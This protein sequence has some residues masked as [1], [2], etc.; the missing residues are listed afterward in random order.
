MNNV[1]KLEEFRVASL[2]TPTEDFAPSSE[3]AASGAQTP[4]DSAVFE[5]G[6]QAGWDDA[7]RAEAEDQKRIGA[8]LAHNLQDLGFTFHEAKGQVLRSLEH[9]LI[10]LSGQLLPKLVSDSAGHLIVENIMPF[11]RQAAEA[12]AEI[13]IAPTARAALEPLIEQAAAFPVT[14]IDEPSLGEGQVI[15][16]AGTIEQEIDFSEAFQKLSDAIQALYISNERSLD[17][18]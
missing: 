1:F 5:A 18:G 14:I 4:N 12:P 3:T 6:Y 2:E 16:R 17:H 11:A 13:I 8:E 15:L 10:E 7:V 9:L